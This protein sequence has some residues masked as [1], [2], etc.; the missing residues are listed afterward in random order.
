M[1]WSENGRRREWEKGR[2]ALLAQVACRPVAAHPSPKPL[3]VHGN[4]GSN[5]IPP[6][7]PRLP[8]PCLNVP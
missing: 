6:C 5:E 3:P 8:L 1:K 2:G 4:L 7:F